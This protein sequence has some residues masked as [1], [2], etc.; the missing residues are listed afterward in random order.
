MKTALV[1]NMFGLTLVLAAGAWAETADRSEPVLA[2]VLVSTRVLEMQEQ[3]DLVSLADGQEGGVH[4][5]GQFWVFGPEGVAA[6]G[7]IRL[8]T[9]TRAVGKIREPAV[10][11]LTNRSAVVLDP[12]QFG[13]FRDFLPESVS[14]QGTVLRAAP[15]RQT[16]WIDLGRDQGLRDGDGILVRR[17][18]LPIARGRVE[19]LDAD[20]ALIALQPLVSNA[21]AEAGDPVELWPGPGDQRQG[22]FTS[23][24]L[25]IRPG[26]DGPRLTLVGT[27]QDGLRVGFMADIYRLGRYVGVAVVEQAGDPLS[28]ARLIEAASVQSPQVGDIAVVR[29]GP[30]AAGFPLGAAIFNVAGDDYALAAAGESDGVQVGEQ[31]IVR[32]P[33]PEDPTRWQA[34]ATLEIQAAHIN[35]FGAVIHMLQADADRILPWE[36]AE[37]PDP[38]WPHWVSVGQVSASEPSGRWAVADMIAAAEVRA[39]AVIRWAAEIGPASPRALGH[40]PRGAGVVLYS[41][42]RRIVFYVPPGW[43]PIE[44][45]EGARL[46]I[47]AILPPIGTSGS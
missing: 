44:S 42:P 34:V 10:E 1:R 23:A 12:G 4:V 14:L 17:L 6:D 18:G 9:P 38:P 35:H 39:G 46:E 43:G 21:L 15:G 3:E 13:R 30:Q 22:R 37:R 29:P 47:P 41:D 5:D 40:H 31:W 28:V 16:A 11:P 32:R 7:Q 33:L 26:S 20:R 24:V 2:S 25:D 8:A 45:L 19:S 27:A 36:W